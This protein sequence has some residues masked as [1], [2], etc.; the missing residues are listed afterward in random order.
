MTKLRDEELVVLAKE[1]GFLP[2]RQELLVRSYDWMKRQIVLNS[3]RMGLAGAEAE[4]A[5]EEGVFSL[6]EAIAKYDTRQ[7]GKK[8]GCSFRSF[9]RQVL[10]ARLRDYCKKMRRS[11]HRYD[12]SA[13]ARRVLEDAADHRACAATFTALPG[14]NLSDPSAEVEWRE[15]L[16]RFQNALRQIDC[17][18]Q[19]L[20]ERLA[21]GSSMHDI[22]TEWGVSYHRIRRWRHRMLAALSD[23]LRTAD[24]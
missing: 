8:D 4:D 17:R 3:R 2:A 15:Q 22:A 21:I 23:H 10:L 16:A 1:C 13:T 7:L 11:R 12:Q 5:Q 6:L 18:L 9:L 14:L 24:I 20:W 19:L